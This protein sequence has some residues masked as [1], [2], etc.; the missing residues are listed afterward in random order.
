MIDSAC[1]KLERLD[2]LFHEQCTVELDGSR[3]HG[4]WRRL[5]ALVVTCVC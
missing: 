4:S 2:F 5:R 3:G 1:P